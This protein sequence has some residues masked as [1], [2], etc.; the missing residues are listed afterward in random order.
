GN[1]DDP[2]GR[3]YSVAEIRHILE[4]VPRAIL[5]V[6]ESCCLGC[7][8]S[9]SQLVREQGNLIVIRSFSNVMGLGG[10]PFGFLLTAPDNIGAVNRFQIG[11]K[12]PAITQAAAQAVLHDLEH[13]ENRIAKVR[14]NMTYLAVKLRS[15]GISARITPSD[16]ILIRVAQPEQVL[17]FL[18]G[19]M[20]RGIDLSRFPKLDKY[21]KIPVRD[22]EY[23]FRVVDAFDKMPRE[24]YLMR[25]V[26]RTGYFLRRAFEANAPGLIDTVREGDTGNPCDVD[27]A[28]L[29]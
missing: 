2:T 12:P 15:M 28:R 29:T 19:R 16:F 14:E 9:V 8:Y 17:S 10:L 4:R 6:D 24:A 20:I 3:V 21:I 23:S 13:I 5:V 27:K 1:P 7:D 26:P 11:R 25:S 22:D 18:S